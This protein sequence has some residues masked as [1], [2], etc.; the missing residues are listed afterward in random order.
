MQDIVGHG[1]EF[2][3]YRGENGKPLKRANECD[4]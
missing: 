3:H 2:G 1:K 4:V